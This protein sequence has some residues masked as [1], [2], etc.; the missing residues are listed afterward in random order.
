M[1]NSSEQTIPG[2]AKR[3]TALLALSGIFGVAAIAYGVYWFIN[4]GKHEDTDNAYVSGNIVQITP[5]IAGTVNAIE[6]QDTDFVKAGQT[7]VKLDG[8]D[9]QVALDQARAQLAQTVREVRTL[10]ANNATYEANV[11]LREAEITRTASE[12]ARAKEDLARRQSVA[13]IGAV[14][15]E[16]LQHAKSNLVAAQSAYAAAQAG[17]LSANE[18]LASNKTLTEGVHVEQHPNV[19]RAAAKFR[20]AYIN[21]QRTNLLSPVTGYVARRSVQLGQ[22]IQAGTPLMAVIPMDQL[23]VDANFK[24]V[25]LRKMRIG[26]PVHLVADMYGKNVVFHGTVEGLGVGTGAAFALLPAQ[27]ATGNWIKV[28]QRVPV[29][30][31]LDPKELAEHPLRIGLSMEVDVDVVDQSGKALAN[32]ENSAKNAEVIPTDSAAADAE[33]KKIIASNIGEK[34]TKA[35]KASKASKED[36]AH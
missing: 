6:A 11:T 31:K 7:L 2:Q 17:V 1:D 19:L 30:I 25:Q 3:K 23:W 10:Y 20:E 21:A 29:R 8:A 15:N 12:L 18:Q 32:T 9:A 36:K 33:I 22:R 28:V 16:E 27:N 4:N 35:T 26:Q 34:S 13:S 5:Q 24:E 14:S